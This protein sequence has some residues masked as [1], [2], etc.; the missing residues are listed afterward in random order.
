MKGF[1]AKSFAEWKGGILL[2]GIVILGFGLYQDAKGQAHGADY[3]HGGSPIIYSIPVRARC[4]ENYASGTPNASCSIPALPANVWCDSDADNLCSL[5]TGTVACSANCSSLE[6]PGTNTLEQRFACAD[7]ATNTCKPAYHGYATIGACQSACAGGNS[8]PPARTITQRYFCD[9]SH[10]IYTCRAGTPTDSTQQTFSSLS[11]CE[12]VCTPTIVEPAPAVSKK[13]TCVNKKEN[14]C[15]EDSTGLFSSEAACNEACREIVTSPPKPTPPPP[16]API[17]NL[18]NCKKTYRQIKNQIKVQRLAFEGSKYDSLPDELKD[19]LDVAIRSAK[20]LEKEAKNN[21]KK[22]LCGENALSTFNEKYEQWDDLASGLEEEGQEAS[23]FYE[24]S[25]EMR[26]RAKREGF[27]DASLQRNSVALLLKN[28]F[29]ESWELFDLSSI[30]R[31][32]ENFVHVGPKFQQ[33]LSEQKNKLF[34]KLKDIEKALAGKKV[35][36]KDKISLKR[37]IEFCI[38]PIYD[39]ATAELME[40]KFAQIALDVRKDESLSGIVADLE[41]FC[42]KRSSES[43]QL[44]YERGAIRFN[45][46]DT[47]EWYFEIF[48]NPKQIAIKGSQGSVNPK[49]T[50]K[51]V[52]AILAILRTVQTPKTEEG[53]CGTL[54]IPKGIEETPPWGACAVHTALKQIGG[55]KQGLETLRLAGSAV[56]P[57][58]REQFALFVWHLTKAEVLTKNILKVPGNSDTKSLCEIFEDCGSSSKDEAIKEA[59]AAMRV[60]GL[61]AGKGNGVW[62]FGQTLLRAEA[63]KVLLLLQEKILAGTK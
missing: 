44:L 42:E 21:I 7:L 56:K 36:D 31:G 33:E 54:D 41:G 24:L 9:T 50:L 11:S 43:N 18:D 2:L 45:D 61:M 26:E 20:A 62:G 57:V 29:S 34:E 40:T 58:T 13:Y 23:K 49:G 5:A 55:G 51:K 22:S 38:K 27:Q 6:I 3:S 37:A 28:I 25:E 8:L 52:E 1:N 19:S 16:P 17:E 10:A 32:V 12:A 35:L 30:Q 15:Q 53:T 39:A 46:V 63:A 48:Q 4:G 60:N 59:V 47:Y 14:I